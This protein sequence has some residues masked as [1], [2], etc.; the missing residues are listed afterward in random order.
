[1]GA[2]A[3]EGRTALVMG[4]SS[5]M[6]AACARLLAEDGSA[7]LIMGRREDALVKARAALLRQ[8]P[9]ARIEIFAGDSCQE[10][11]VKTALKRA[12]AMSGRLDILVST[13]GGAEIKPLLLQDAGTFMHEYKI[14]VISAFLMVRYGVPLMEPGGAIVCISTASVIQPFAG[15]SAYAAAKAALERFV[16]A[17]AHE[18]GGAK[19]RINAVR[20]GMTRT[21]AT[22]GMYDVPG[23]VDRYASETLLGRTGE[24][25]DIARVMRFLA[26]PE[27]AWITGESISAD[28]GQ[29]Q[30]KIPDMLDDM[31]GRDVMAKVRA[32][33][34]PP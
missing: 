4:G 27:S 28:G 26:G 16:R 33:K 17:A 23:L 2:R 29:D 20:P 30:G 12:H 14:N 10:E 18:L 6:G 3:L 22:A 13:V 24:P 15:L 34:S 8:V 1:M 7:V 19:I 5:G 9:G 31:F 25:D 32:G 11:A 21:A